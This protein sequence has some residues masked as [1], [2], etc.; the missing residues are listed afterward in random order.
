MANKKIKNKI[1]TL[2]VLATVILVGLVIFL[3]NRQADK[4]PKIITA[5]FQNLAQADSFRAKTQLVI[6][7]PEK[8]RNRQ[9]PLTTIT[10]DLDTDLK[11][12][13]NYP[14]L[15]GLLNMQA[16]GPGNTFYTNGDLRVLADAVMFRLGEFPVLLNPSGNL[17]GRW[18]NV[19]ATLLATKNSAEVQA[20]LSDLASSLSYQGRGDEKNWLRFHGVPSAEN[21]GQLINALRLDASGNHGFNV[22]ARLLAANNIDSLDVWIDGEAQQLRKITAHFVRPL[23]NDKV[24]DFATLTLELSDFN[25]NVTIDRPR[26][27]LTVKPAAFSGIFGQG[28]IEEIKVEKE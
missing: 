10:V 4:N 22:L 8:L 24:F 9:R 26:A 2:A 13:N 12:E 28:K 3:I 27:E 20:A 7:L 21:E 23:P 25:K 11:N 18:T 19:S 5:A 17:T 16:R 6:N 14:S 15:T 1:K